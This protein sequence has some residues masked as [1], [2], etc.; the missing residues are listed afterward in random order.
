MAGCLACA[1]GVSQVSLFVSCRTILLRGNSGWRFVVG[2]ARGSV[3]EES[4]FTKVSQR[5]AFGKLRGETV[6]SSSRLSREFPALA[7]A[8]HL[9]NPTPLSG[10]AY[11]ISANGVNHKVLVRPHSRLRPSAGSIYTRLVSAAAPPTPLILLSNMPIYL[12]K[13]SRR[14]FSNLNTSAT[15]SYMFYPS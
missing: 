15:V 4:G 3:V 2:Q 8:D 14:G 1:V 7:G 11:P 13:R 9:T 12:R 10:P 5:G 6:A